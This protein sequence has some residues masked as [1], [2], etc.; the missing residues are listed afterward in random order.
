MENL[1]KCFWCEENDGN[2]FENGVALCSECINK[3]QWIREDTN[4]RR[5]EYY[6]EIDQISQKVYLGNEDG[7]REKEKLA[8]LGVNRILN[9]ASACEIYHPYDFEYKQLYLENEI[10]ENIKKYFKDCIEFIERSDKIFVHCRMGMSR[11]ATI[12]IAYIMWKEKMAFVTA[13]EFV[14]S[15]RKCIYPN[16]GFE[17]QLKEFEKELIKCDYNLELLDCI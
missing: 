8:S 11:S 14:K 16:K 7:A 15:K 4:I 12:V 1:E 10:N 6:P 2:N 17:N 3:K 5:D 9:C 13:K